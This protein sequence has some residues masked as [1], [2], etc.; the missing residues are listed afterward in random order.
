MWR[1]LS[2]CL[3]SGYA[4][5]RLPL[6]LKTGNKSD[7]FV[8]ELSSVFFLKGGHQGLADKG[9]VDRGLET[10]LA[11]SERPRTEAVGRGRL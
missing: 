3:Y 8:P 4:Y 9:E 5:V 2:S 7:A 1:V 10:V 6:V 11:R